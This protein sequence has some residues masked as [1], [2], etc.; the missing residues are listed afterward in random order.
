MKVTYQP[1]LFFLSCRGKIESRFVQLGEASP[2]L[3]HH[4]WPILR[5]AT[6]G[7]QGD[8]KHSINGHLL[9]ITHSQNVSS[10]LVV[11]VPF[12]HIFKFSKW[13]TAHYGSILENCPPAIHVLSVISSFHKFYDTLKY[14]RFD[15]ILFVM[16][17]F[18]FF[19]VSLGA[20]TPECSPNLKKIQS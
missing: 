1:V 13:K 14:F 15:L 19:Q 5:R 11:A 12:P 17:W 18:F 10:V 2:L 9:Q 6:T 8:A 7:E 16:G 20:K 4:C 3:A